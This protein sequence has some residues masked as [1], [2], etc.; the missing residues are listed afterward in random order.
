MKAV[1]LAVMI[2]LAAGGAHAQPGMGHGDHGM[3]AKTAAKAQTTHR[4][5][6]T[7]KKA[8]VRAGTVQL[9]HEPVKSLNWPA[10]TMAFKV[11]DKALLDKL[12]EGRK[13]EVDFEQIGKDYVITAVR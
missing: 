11:Q 6:G 5:V 7:V 12:G 2:G 8:D 9:A 10:M 3:V 4:A 1:T 13:V